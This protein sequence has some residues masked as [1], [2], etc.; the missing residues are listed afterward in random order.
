MVRVM[1]LTA[2]NGNGSALPPSFASSSS[3]CAFRTSSKDITAAGAPE[4]APA[5][6][7]IRHRYS[8]QQTRFVLNGGGGGRGG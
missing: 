6:C 2:C 8:N 1:I 4:P 7:E 3:V 5:P